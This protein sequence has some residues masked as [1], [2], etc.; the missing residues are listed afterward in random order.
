ME[1]ASKPVVGV[2]SKQNPPRAGAGRI[3]APAGGLSVC[4]D[5]VRGFRFAPPLA[6]SVAPFGARLD[7]SLGQSYC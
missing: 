1:A 4:D 3:S 7:A 6:K 2:R 5:V